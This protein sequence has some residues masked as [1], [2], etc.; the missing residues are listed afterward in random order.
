MISEPNFILEF[1][2]DLGIYRATCRGYITVSGFMRRLDSSRLW[3]LPEDLQLVIDYRKSKFM[4]FTFSN[5]QKTVLTTAEMLKRF[6]SVRVAIIHSNPTD[7]ARSVLFTNMLKHCP[8]FHYKIFV[9]YKGALD[10]LCK[11]PFIILN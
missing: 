8:N 10:W 6:R 9:T 3:N 5:I 7:Q 11:S 2:P 4:D 1:I